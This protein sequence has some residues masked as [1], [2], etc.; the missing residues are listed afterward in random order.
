MG[1]RQHLSPKADEQPNILVAQLNHSSRLAGIE[2]IRPDLYSITC[3]AS[4]VALSD[5]NLSLRSSIG[6]FRKIQRVEETCQEMRNWWD[7]IEI[8]RNRSSNKPLKDAVTQGDWFVADP[9]LPEPIEVP[10]QS[11][12]TGDSIREPDPTNLPAHSQ[13]DVLQEVAPLDDVARNLVQSYVEALYLS[14]TSL[15]YFPKNTLSKSWAAIGDLRSNSTRVTAFLDTVKTM[16]LKNATFDKKYRQILPEA[17]KEFSARFISSPSMSVKKR[18]KLKKPKPGKNG[19]YSIE[20]D[21]LEHCWR[22]QDPGESSQGNLSQRETLLAAIRLREI[23]LQ[24][25]LVLEV[26]GVEDQ[27]D[28]DKSDGCTTD[29]NNIHTPHFKPKPSKD[30]QKSQKCFDF[31][32]V[33]DTLVDRLCIWQSIEAASADSK[34]SK[35]AETNALLSKPSH[36]TEKDELRDFYYQVLVP[37]Y[38]SRLPRHVEKIGKQM[39]VMSEKSPAKHT[40]DGK[41]VA[42]GTK[43]QR[44]RPALH[45]SSS[46]NIPQ[47]KRQN[48]FKPPSLPRSATDSVLRLEA[49]E[50]SSTPLE[51]SIKGHRRTLSRASSMS[52][53]T[54]LS[55]VEVDMT[56][57]SR[58]NESRSRK[59]SGVDT[60]LQDAIATLKKPNRARAVREY[61][62]S[63][64]SR[65]PAMPRKPWLKSRMPSE[66][67]ATPR[68]EHKFKRP[69]QE[70]SNQVSHLQEADEDQIPSTALQSTPIKSRGRQV[71]DSIER[72]TSHS[73][74]LL[75]RQTNVLETPS[76]KV[77]KWK[78]ALDMPE[79]QDDELVP[80]SSF[81]PPAQAASQDDVVRRSS[82]PF[83]GGSEGKTDAQHDILNKSI[84][85]TLGWDDDDYDQYM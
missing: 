37:F 84:Y 66:V 20:L 11:R 5:L 76:R 78:D 15:A 40:Y 13:P 85:Q 38:A 32:S 10:E 25:I 24:I 16:I 56:A 34:A 43:I 14:K 35:D 30:S 59:S 17:I 7:D 50:R 55:R 47:A 79:T 42:P 53:S 68:K 8:K 57:I 52:S 12:L 62:D 4:R 81:K 46:G 63:A 23:F 65:N 19:L 36:A 83:R 28:M 44:R 3:F 45:E 74:L 58:F 71:E 64:E 9:T 21:A 26:L 77:S 67:G 69:A 60:E 2:R 29:A 1:L 18:R 6:P 82:S 49:R 80:A 27:L 61:V 31:I 73:R 22:N 70:F 54:K 51:Q 33:L 48:G 72:S 75:S 41:Q 39:G